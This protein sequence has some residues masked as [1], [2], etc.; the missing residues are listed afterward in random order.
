MLEHGLCDRPWKIYRPKNIVTVLGMGFNNLEFGCAQSAGL[1]QEFG[2]HRDL[3]DIVKAADDA[4]SLD[5]AIGQTKLGADGRREAADASL[6]TRRIGVAHLD[7][8]RYRIDGTQ[9]RF[10][11]LREILFFAFLR[12][13]AVADVL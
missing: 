10:L 11:R 9:H 8:R 6:M 13:L 2:R 1:A 3:A 12:P 5:F 7:H 4:Q